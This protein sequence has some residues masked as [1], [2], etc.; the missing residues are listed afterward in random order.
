MNL[1]NVSNKK[2]DPYSVEGLRKLAS[3]ADDLGEP[4]LYK[5]LLEIAANQLESDAVTKKDVKEAVMLM[6]FAKTMQARKR[7]APATNSYIKAA[8]KLKYKLVI[9]LEP[10]TKKL[11]MS[12]EPITGAERT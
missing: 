5:Q 3:A 10:D 8:E 12:F 4:Y 2:F 9:K 1:K 7:N 6:V 11:K